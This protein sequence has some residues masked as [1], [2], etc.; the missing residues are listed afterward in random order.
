[1]FDNKPEQ[2]F[3][4]FKKEYINGYKEVEKNEEK[5]VERVE[6]I[7]PRVASAAQMTRDQMFAAMRQAMAA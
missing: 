6:K 7:A 3:V 1:L 2:K 4:E 5:K